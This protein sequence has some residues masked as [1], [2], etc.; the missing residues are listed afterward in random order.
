ML[1]VSLSPCGVNL[2]FRSIDLLERVSYEVFDVKLLKF[3]T[4]QSWRTPS[5][6]GKIFLLFKSVLRG[7]KILE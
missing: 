4:F 6:I 5:L 2:V 1:S 3:I 7:G